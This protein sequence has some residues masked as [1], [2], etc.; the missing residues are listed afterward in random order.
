MMMSEGKKKHLELAE[1][2]EDTWIHFT[3]FHRN[4]WKHGRRR[5]TKKIKVCRKQIY[6]KRS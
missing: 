2:Y 3:V 4:T 5:E 1:L 6:K